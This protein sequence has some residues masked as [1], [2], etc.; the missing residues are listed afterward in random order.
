MS[1]FGFYKTGWLFLCGLLLVLFANA[2]FGK[3]ALR[4]CA[5]PN[6]LPFSNRQQEGFENK[7]AAL[8]ADALDR[9]LEYIWFPQRMGFIRNTLKAPAE[10][11]DGFKC[12][13]V[14]GVPASFELIATTRP[15]YQSSYALV[16]EKGR[17]LD[18]IH[19][20][21]DLMMLPASR[22]DEL[23]IG[24]FDRT[25]AAK[26]LLNHGLID[27][28]ISYQAMNGDPNRYPGEIIEEDL[29]EGR[30]D[31]AITWGPIA[32]Y[33]SQQSDREL[34]MIPLK[35]EPGTRF[36]FK[37]AMGVRYGEPDWKD[38][39]DR[40]LIEKKAEIHEILLEYNVPLVGS[41]KIGVEGG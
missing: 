1:L 21:F 23:K 32:G 4:V 18:D 2:S 17:G 8:F 36:D 37:I 20:A 5:D 41:V 7:I 38:Q 34:V 30:L 29:Q 13:L 22:R 6:N 11:R 24:V 28:I 14:M 39:M 12:D 3:Q 9:D 27:Q 31:A 10:N 15:Y 33:F 16:F 40:L 26:W 25:P 19:S 35:S